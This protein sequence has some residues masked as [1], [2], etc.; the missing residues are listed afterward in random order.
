MIT[1]DV[2]P[3]A[4]SQ[5]LR[6]LAAAAVVDVDDIDIS[7]AAGADGDGVGGRDHRRQHR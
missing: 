5:L 2:A 6:K 4:G 3:T 7:N 1:F